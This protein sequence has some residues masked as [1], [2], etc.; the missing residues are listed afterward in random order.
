[1]LADTPARGPCGTRNK[2]AEPMKKNRLLCNAALGILVE[3][4]FALLIIILGLA[5]AQ[6]INASR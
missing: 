5:L 4:V 6:G 2:R 1:M 3:I